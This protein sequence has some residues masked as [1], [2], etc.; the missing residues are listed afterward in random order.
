MMLKNVFILCAALFQVSIC[1]A[2]TSQNPA[3]RAVSFQAASPAM[4]GF[5]LIFDIDETQCKSRYGKKWREGCVTALGL[6]GAVEKNL[7][8]TPKV[9][10]SWRWSDA[11]RVRFVPES[12]DLIRPD[13]VY[14]VK[15]DKMFLPRSVKLN[16]GEAQVKT[17]TR[18]VRLLKSDFLVDPAPSPAHRLTMALAFNYPVSDPLN[19]KLV[20]IVGMVADKPEIIWNE[21][22][23]QANISW[24]IHSLPKNPEYVRMELSGFDQW[25]KDGEVERFLPPDKGGLISFS[26]DMP[27]ETNVFKIRGVELAKTVD[28]NLNR[29]FCLRLETTL[30]ANPSDVLEKLSVWELPEKISEG[31]SRP[32]DWRE[33]PTISADILSRSRKLLL[34]ANDGNL[35]ARSRMS[36]GLPARA[37][38]YLLVRVDENLQSVSGSRLGKP[39]YAVLRVPDSQ[40]SL[41][42]LQPGNMLPLTGD[43][44]VEIY[45]SDVERI[46]WKAEKISEPFLALLGRVVHEPFSGWGGSSELGYDM[47]A[48]LRQGEIRLSPGKEGEAR[49][50]TLELQDLLPE[51]DGK[52]GGPL[53]L[54]LTGYVKDQPVAETS[55]LFMPTDFALIVKDGGDGNTHCFVGCISS[56]K[57]A[58]EVDV[59]VLGANGKPVMSAVTDSAGHAVFPSLASFRRE[60]KAVAVVAERGEDLAWL[61]LEDRTRILNTSPFPT[62]GRHVS[63]NDAAVH[64]FS[65]R[66]VYRPGDRLNFGVIAR[67]GNFGLLPDDLPFY[68]EIRDPRGILVREEPFRAGK[69]GLA[70]ICWQSPPSAITGK[71]LFNVRQARGADILA[72]VPVRVEEYAPETIRMRINAPAAKGWLRVNEK[73][74]RKIDFQLQ[75]LF[76][77]PAQ[78]SRIKADLQTAPALFVFSEYAEY[79]FTDARPF[80]GEGRKIRLSEGVTDSEGN[81]GFDLPCENLAHFSSVVTVNAEAI[82]TGGG[83]AA[84]AQASFL[85]SPMKNIVGYKLGSDIANPEF[86]LRNSD[87]TL[88]LIALDSE[89]NRVSLEDLSYILQRKSWATSLVEDGSGGYRYDDVPV[90]QIIRSGSMTIAPEGSDFRLDTT[91]AGEFIL[92]M[93][94]SAGERVAEFQYR[95]AGPSIQAPDRPLAGSRMRLALDRKN[96]SPGDE[97]LLALVSPYDCN[98]LITIE[99]D[100][101]RNFSWF[102]AKAGESLHRIKIPEDFEGKGYVSVIAGRDTNSPA[103]YMEPVSHV[104]APFTSNMKARDMGLKIIAPKEVLPGS[105]LEIEVSATTPGRFILAAVDEGILLLDDFP[106]PDPLQDLLGSRALDVSTHQTLDLL[107]PSQEQLRNMISPFGGGMGGAPFGVR[108][109]NPFKRKA[110]APVAWWSGIVDYKEGPV[111]I[112]IPVP[113]YYNGAIRLVAVGAGDRNCGNAVARVVAAGP[114]AVMPRFPVAAVPGDSFEGAIVIENR[115]SERRKGKIRLTYPPALKPTMQ[116]REDFEIEPNGVLVLPCA[117]A[118]EDSPGNCQIDLELE[119]ERYALKRSVTMSV[120]PLTPRYFSAIS[121]RIAKDGKLVPTRS[122][123]ETLARTSLIVDSTPFPL[124]A[125]FSN[126]LETYPYGCAEQLISRAFGQLMLNDPQKREE[127]LKLR[128]SA[129]GIIRE[130]AN[131]SGIAPWPGAEAEP[132][133]TVY[134]LDYLLTLAEKRIAANDD[135]VEMLAEAV[136]SNCALNEADLAAA[137]SIAYGIWVLTRAGRITTRHLASLVSAME[138]R[139]LPWRMDLTGVLI[140]ASQK[141]MKMKV[142]SFPRPVFRNSR[143]WLDEYSQMALYVALMNRYFPES[144]DGKMK[145]EFYEATITNINES[146]YATFSSSQ[147]LRALRS[148]SVAAQPVLGVLRIKCAEPADAF[149]EWKNV[150]RLDAPLCR[151]FQVEGVQENEQL[152]W[153]I[154]QDGHDRGRVIKPAANGLKIQKIILDE[155]GKPTVKVNQ[156][157]VLTISVTIESEDG[158]IHDCVISDLLPGGVEML[159]PRSEMD[160]ELLE[161]TDNI[162]R[163]EDRMIVFAK[164]DGTPKSFAWKARAVNKGIFATPPAYA[165]DMFNRGIHGNSESGSLEVG[166]E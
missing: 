131:Y 87:A 75:N 77:T 13:T 110:E 10:G 3:Y 100:G 98:G 136:E 123:F 42:F 148:L 21:Q 99:R 68:A 97:I 55:R 46:T 28:E 17:P 33:A 152:F 11:N 95:V 122:L 32:Y 61:P 146:A 89:L 96:Y 93:K 143:D 82:E 116:V 158:K 30:Y 15:L 166:E 165:E 90:G 7:E 70:E 126:Y 154:I 103:I 138:E 14:T 4:D 80:A 84:T 41:G 43:G 24:A 140:A 102:K 134:G 127:E 58:A 161:K 105:M 101:I 124:M 164:A 34:S 8:L 44:R 81:A 26:Q 119:S 39:F 159:F 66:G 94:N 113:D 156:G 163:L 72:S 29:Q 54:T 63:E 149:F 86:I 65:E 76:G 109:Q 104:I 129:I 133:L 22:K 1:W 108:F 135:L 73:D 27:G 125:A 67:K 18:A 157:D 120:R 118:V 106:V 153:Q 12:P 59:K 83:R 150:G 64:A 20:K 74:V 50:S 112:A 37:D 91:E 40:A 128:T 35:S 57:P 69:D 162:Q 144:L 132:L 147:G 9:R 5:L 53:R 88:N 6:P 56:G 16:K 38:R 45:S 107:M 145:E 71:Y 36:F 121:G 130:R 155:A 160:T 111:K 117:F 151:S 52:K 2:A 60:K 92:L 139:G 23:S 114:L 48:S 19:P 142:E 79:V 51:G 49:Y 78:G 25:V 47:L 115:R 31:A 85:V 141:E 137:R 62:A